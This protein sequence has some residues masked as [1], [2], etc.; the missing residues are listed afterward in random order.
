MGICI[1]GMVHHGIRMESA[2]KRMRIVEH[3]HQ[4]AE[5]TIWKSAR[6]MERVRH[7]SA[8]TT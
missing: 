3:H 2:E 6:M 4:T 7:K 1:G 5:N 8:R